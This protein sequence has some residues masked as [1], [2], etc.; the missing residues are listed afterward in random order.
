MDEKLRAIPEIKHYKTNFIIYSVIT[1]LLFFPV[2]LKYLLD[3]NFQSN[4]LLVM[5]LFYLMVFF[6][7]LVIYN[8]VKYIYY[9]RLKPTFVQEAKLDKLESKWSTYMCFIVDMNFNGRIEEVET[10]RIFKPGP[11]AVN[12]IDKYMNRRVLVGYDELKKQAV[13][14][15]LLD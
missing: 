14:V 5:G 13:I 1:F 7:P 12:R 15:K 8:F 4:E 2:L 10:K 3:E 11:V 6:L 9:L